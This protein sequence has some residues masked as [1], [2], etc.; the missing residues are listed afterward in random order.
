MGEGEVGE[1]RRWDFDFWVL[2]GFIISTGETYHWERRGWRGD[3]S[4]G[5]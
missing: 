2:K 3:G 4:A 5:L 1:E